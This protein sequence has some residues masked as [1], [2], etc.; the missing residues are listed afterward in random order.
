MFP[1]WCCWWRFDSHDEDGDDGGENV[2]EYDGGENVDEDDGGENV[3]A[4]DA[5]ENV[6]E[7]DAGEDV[8][9]DDAGENVDE[10]DAEGCSITILVTGL[11][12]S[13]SGCYRWK[14]DG[15]VSRIS[16]HHG[17]YPL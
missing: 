14:Y 13:S 16:L 17:P 11:C 12:A 6:D 9:E 7:V 10:D 4:D 15:W 1:W 8:D 2:V 3:D 5:G